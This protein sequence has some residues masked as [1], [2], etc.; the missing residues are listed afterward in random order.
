MAKAI[1][2]PRRP[3]ISPNNYAIVD[4]RIRDLT[5]QEFG[6]LVALAPAGAKNGVMRWYC[7]RSCPEQTVCVVSRLN[8]QSGHTRSCGCLRREPTRRRTHGLS[9]TPTYECRVRMV[10]RCVNPR[11]PDYARYGAS[12]IHVCDRWRRSFEAFLSDMGAR[13][14]G[15]HTVDRIVGARG[16]DCGGRPDCRARG[17]PP[18]CRWATRKERNRNKSNVPPYDFRGETKTLP[19]L[20]ERFD[21]PRRLVYQRL[22]HGRELERALTTSVEKGRHFIDTAEGPRHLAALAR[23]RGIDQ[24]VLKKRLRAGWPLEEAL[25]T[26]AGGRPSRNRTVTFRGETKRLIYFARELGLPFLAVRKRID[27]LGWPVEKALTTPLR[28][29]RR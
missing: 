26:P 6:R 18:N 14:S 27:V 7:R 23:E 9:R 25:S 16:Y 20:A 8:L 17:V 15:G 21:M 19:E 10:Q 13:P 29:Q 4:R 11:N 12:G 1:V 5:G 24:H 2:R 22:R 3:A 28:K